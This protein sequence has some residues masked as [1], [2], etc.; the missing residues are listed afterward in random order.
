MIFCHVHRIT[1]KCGLARLSQKSGQ[2][3]TM[4]M[5]GF[6]MT[7]RQLSIAAGICAILSGCGTITQGPTQTITFLSDPSGA[8]CELWQNGRWR[9]ATLTT[10]ASITVRKT[11]YDMEMTCRKEGYQEGTTTLVSGY[12]LGTFGN[13][14]IG[15]ATGWA[16][17]SATGS[18]N[19]YPSTA[20][21]SLKPLPPAHSPALASIIL[22]D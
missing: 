10:P 15:G 17:D 5:L 13:F 1:S 14:I 11:K 9:V 20:V 22:P 16:I 3:A 4:Q 18:D 12:G 21:V 19:K 2:T 7:L 8:D 6:R